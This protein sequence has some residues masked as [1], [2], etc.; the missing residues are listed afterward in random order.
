MYKHLYGRSFLEDEI[1]LIN[2]FGCSS[3]KTTLKF[4]GCHRSQTTLVLLDSDCKTTSPNSRVTTEALKSL[5]YPDDFINSNC[6]YIGSK[7]FEDAF[8]SEDL[9]A[10]LNQFYPKHNSEP[11]E[12]SDV[13][14]FREAG[15]KFGKELVEHV[16]KTCQPHLRSSMNKPDFSA[17]LASQCCN[18]HQVPQVIHDVFQLLRK[19]VGVGGE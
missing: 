19:K 7:E 1:V 4:L 16:Q 11:W 17:K 13:D 18:P 3:W 9:V 6:F 5:S 15:C 10:T 12:N 2:L 14:R 8:Q